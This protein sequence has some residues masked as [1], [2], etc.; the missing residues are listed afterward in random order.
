MQDGDGGTE[1]KGPDEEESEGEEEEGRLRG[2]CQ[3]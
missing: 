3:I 2:L 1:A